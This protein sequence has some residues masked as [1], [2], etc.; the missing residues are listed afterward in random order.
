MSFPALPFVTAGLRPDLFAGAGTQSARRA[1]LIT[2]LSVLV[3]AGFAF[4]ANGLSS[5]GLS[6]DELNKLSA[7]T[8]YRTQGLTSANGE[9]PLL[10][11][12]LLTVSVIAAE[13]W[14]QTSLVA[15]HPELN[16][17][18]ETSLRFPVALFGA[19]AAVLIYLVASELFGME[20]GL[21]AAAL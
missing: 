1:L 2:A 15:G 7:V 19:F 13:K 21:I 16:V 9:H 14:N 18:V 8:E 20:T 10:M 12:A 3:L 4:R 6:E 11:K 5:E 17:P